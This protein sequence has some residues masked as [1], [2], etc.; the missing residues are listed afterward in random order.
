MVCALEGLVEIMK[1]QRIISIFMSFILA[2]SLLFTFDLEVKA[3][4]Q[5]DVVSQLNSYIAQYNGKTANSNQMYMGSQCKGFANWIFLKIFGVYIGPYPE[6]ANYKITNPN[7]ETI[8]IIEPGNL[9]EETAKALLKKGVPGD[10][11]QVQRSTARGRGPHSMILAGV[12]D[13]GIEVFDC[14]SDGRNTIKKYSISWSAFDT[15]N[16][17]MSLYHAYGYTV[18]TNTKPVNPTVSKN[19]VWYDIKD[20]IELKVHA[21]GATSYFMSIF[22]DGSKIISQGIDGTYAFDASAY[23][24][25]NYSAYFSCTNG[26]GTIDTEWIDFSVVGAAGYS[27]V[28]TSNWWYDL[29]DTVSISV[30]TICAK[31]QVIGI[32]KEGVGRIITEDTERTY[33]IAASELGVGVYSAYFSVYNGSGGIDT[34]RVSFEIVDIPKEGAVLSTAKTSYT[35]ND[36]VQVSVLVYC[37]KGQVIGIDDKIGNRRVITEEADNGTYSV[38]ASKLGRGKYSAY[39]SVFNSSGGYDTS[40]IEFAIDNQLTN[41]EISIEKNSYEINEDIIVSASANGGVE[42]YTLKVYNVSG[43]EVLKKDFTGHH[44]TVSSSELGEGMYTAKVTCTNYAFESDTR[45]ISFNIGNQVISEE[46]ESSDPDQ[47]V[48]SKEDAAESKPGDKEDTPD[49]PD[50]NSGDKDDSLAENSGDKNDSDSEAEE[51]DD[52]EEGDVFQDDSSNAEYEVIAVKGNAV[53]VEY[54]ENTN[55]KATVIRIPATIEAAD[56]TVCK[57]TSIAGSAFR[58]NRKIKKVIVGSNVGTIGT[59]AFYGCKNLTSVSLSQNLTAIGA[60]AFSGCTKLKS[61][62][63]PSKVKKIGSNAFYGC[64]NLKKLT[65]KTTKLT[66]KGL[67]KKAWK[68]IPAKASVRVPA[69][70]QKAYQK[71]FCK[72]GMSRKIKVK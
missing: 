17:A 7:A 36:T 64:K 65:V 61:L 13:G 5:S 20:R 23:G 8:G 49:I 38:P 53:C 55:P 26:A 16:R 21:D 12:N 52:M 72:K 43:T 57:V 11:I 59:N 56:G 45:T 32:D 10:Y 24:Y 1:R 66:S 48:G 70:K 34:K 71:L 46:P 2:V 30:D 22:K 69:G 15:A 39:F 62:T 14:N 47:N 68:G 58:K 67:G 6:S 40:R 63:I 51:S 37:S 3:I 50:S 19:Q 33:T 44:I 28:Y 4:S 54:T 29:T 31:G 9:N 25:G 35:L 42:F 60:N 18:S 41:P 27:D